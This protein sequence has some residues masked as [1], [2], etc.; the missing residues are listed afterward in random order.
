MSLWCAFW[1]R[2]Q[3]LAFWIDD[4]TG[5]ERAGTFVTE[6]IGHITPKDY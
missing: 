5:T 3:D 4:V 2:V 1:S 6:L